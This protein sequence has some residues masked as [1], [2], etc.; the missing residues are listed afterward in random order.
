MLCITLAL[1]PAMA[2]DAVTTID[3]AD[4]LVVPTM[5]PIS[6]EVFSAPVDHALRSNRRTA[7]AGGGLAW[8]MLKTRS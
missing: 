8:R 2:Q 3:A 6:P 1:L 7:L 4:G 5:L